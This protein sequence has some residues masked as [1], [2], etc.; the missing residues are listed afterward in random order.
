[1]IMRL[2]RPGI[3][4][5]GQYRRWGAEE[6]FLDLD[7]SKD[8]LQGRYQVIEGARKRDRQGVAGVST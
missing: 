2:A 1:M 3:P 7:V 4:G 6:F 5:R 8:Y